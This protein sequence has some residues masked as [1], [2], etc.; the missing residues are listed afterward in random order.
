MTVVPESDFELLR[1]PPPSPIMLAMKRA[2]PTHANFA[3]VLESVVG[4]LD[5]TNAMRMR[6][7]N[8]GVDIETFVKE[9]ASID[10]SQI[11]VTA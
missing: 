5:A 11:E 8:E 10:L 6:M 2:V 1:V 9:E 4:T 3:H 7:Q